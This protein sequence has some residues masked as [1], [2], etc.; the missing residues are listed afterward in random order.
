MVA[1]KRGVISP[2]KLEQSKQ[3]Q[4]Y[5]LAWYMIIFW[6]LHFIASSVF[7]V[8]QY[9]PPNTLVTILNYTCIG[10]MLFLGGDEAM[11]VFE[12]A[13]TLRAGSNSKASKSDEK[14]NI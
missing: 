2:E 10:S 9:H 6:C 8:A 5:A 3:K 14:Q 11:K 1:K 13:K 12:R 7:S 4:R